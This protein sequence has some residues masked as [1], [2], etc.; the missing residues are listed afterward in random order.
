MQVRWNNII[1]SILVIAAVVVLVKFLPAI[2]AVLT[3]VNQIGP[4]H[5][6]DDKVTGLVAIGFLGALL[7]AVVKILTS[8][9]S[10]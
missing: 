4:G 3:T 8:S 9:Q 1:A 7:V 10:K 2:T 5:S 6:T